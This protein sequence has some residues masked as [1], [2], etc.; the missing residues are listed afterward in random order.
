MI[1]IMR[2]KVT[3]WQ[4]LKNS[5]IQREN[6]YIQKGEEREKKGEEEKE[7]KKERGGA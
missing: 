5:S 3:K 6:Q 1:T 2:E 4:S 7:K